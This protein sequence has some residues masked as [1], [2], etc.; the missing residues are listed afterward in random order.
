LRRGAGVLVGWP[1]KRP[2]PKPWIVRKRSTVLANWGTYHQDP[3]AAPFCKAD[4]SL[5]VRVLSD[6]D[7]PFWRIAT[8]RSESSR[9]GIPEHHDQRF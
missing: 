6:R 5:R 8:S 7:Q 4:C 2:R 1:R 3:Q 9:P